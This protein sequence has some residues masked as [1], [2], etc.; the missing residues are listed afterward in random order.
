MSQGIEFFVKNLPV[1]LPLIALEL[2]LLAGALIHLLRHKAVR[3]GSVAL[4]IAIIV[5]VQII[6]PALYFLIGKEED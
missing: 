2:G 3:R 5:L 6:G 1:F 4:W